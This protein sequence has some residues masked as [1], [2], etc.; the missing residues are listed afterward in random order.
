L[1]ERRG[2][3][4]RAIKIFQVGSISLTREGGCVRKVKQRGA[5]PP[6]FWE[7]VDNENDKN[8]LTKR[9]QV[10][11]RVSGTVNL[12][13]VRVFHYLRFSKV[14]REE[15]VEGLGEGGEGQA[16]FTLLAMHVTYRK[17]KRTV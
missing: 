6:M 1:R 2:R 10:R 5:G 16:R 17:L 7:E 12:G 14:L 15:K 13:E 8:G 4:E 11:R 9:K 3:Q